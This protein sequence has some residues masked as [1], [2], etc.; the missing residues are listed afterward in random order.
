MTETGEQAGVDSAEGTNGA[1]ISVCLSG[2][3]HRASLFG[4]GALLYLVDAGK[5]PELASIASISGGSLTN[6]YVGLNTDLSQAGDDAAR[7]KFWSDVKPLART[8]ST[9][10]TVW[11]SWLTYLYLLVLAGILAVATWL[12]FPLGV[13]SSVGVWIAALVVVGWLATKRS[14]VARASFDAK[15]FHGKRLSEMQPGVDHVI[16]AAD[17]QTAEQ[18]Y[19]SR[20]FVCSYRLSWGVPNDLKVAW[21]A[22]A[23]ACLPGAFA[24]VA[25]PASAFAFAQPRKDAPKRV[26]LVDGGVY[27]NMGTQ[28]PI[29]V[30][31]R[32]KAP[33]VPK[34]PPLVPDEVIVVNA[35]AA[36]QVEPR[37]T[38]RW[39]LIGEF[40]SLIADKDIMYD[41]TTAVRRRLLYARFRATRRGQPEQ[42]AMNGV[43][44]QIDRSPLALAGSFAG[45]SDDA[46][47]RA[48]KVLDQLSGA[49]DWKAE[50]KANAAVKTTLSRIKAER[51]AGLLRHAY[52]LV[53]AEAV[54][55]LDY[56]LIDLP[57]LER[58]IELVKEP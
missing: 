46:A 39:P 15:L 8:V 19:F 7:Q 2:G 45:G 6:A 12:C 37:R 52:A 16:A 56:P 10:G 50:A 33:G 55:L 23:S 54:V 17:L 20:R 48:Q 28:W 53:M 5:G 31:D 38:A 40:T 42:P 18:V 41:Q 13:W 49:A 58:F 11:A 1:H 51:A 25:K 35:S 47:A 34:P 44:A 21:A 14:A 36:M 22:Q 27:D 32:I 24:P 3:G 4:L 43:I 26:L 57:P 9:G 29:N 30:D